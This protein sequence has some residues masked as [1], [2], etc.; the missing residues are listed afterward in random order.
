MNRTTLHYSP[1]DLAR[2]RSDGNVI[3]SAAQPDAVAFAVFR[4]DGSKVWEFAILQEPHH[5]DS[6]IRQAAQWLM[7]NRDALCIYVYTPGKS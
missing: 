6:N 2:A 1:E 4:D 5:T 3:A 7:N